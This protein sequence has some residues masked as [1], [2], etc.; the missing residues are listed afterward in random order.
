MKTVLIQFHILQE[1]FLDRGLLL[2]KE[3]INARVSSGEVD[4]IPC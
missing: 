3:S 4:I 1:N 2:S